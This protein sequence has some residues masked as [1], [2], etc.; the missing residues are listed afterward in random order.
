M[1]FT[2]FPLSQPGADITSYVSQGALIASYNDY[3]NFQSANDE[4]GYNP[5]TQ[6]SNTW[7]DGLLLASG[8]SQ[9]NINTAIYSLESQSNGL[10]PDGYSNGSVIERCFKAIVIAAVPEPTRPIT[11][12]PPCTL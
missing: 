8:M 5:L 6:N 4:P 12:R 1:K 2:Q 7:A 10:V 11:T 3:V 9:T